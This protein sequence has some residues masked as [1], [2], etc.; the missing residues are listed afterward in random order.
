LICANVREQRLAEMPG[1][2]HPRRTERKFSRI[3]A[4]GA[5][6]VSQ[7][8]HIDL[9]MHHHEHRH[10][11]DERDRREGLVRFERHR[12][13]EELVDALNSRRGHQQR[14]A[15]RFRL[16]DDVGSDIAASTRLVFDDDR[17]AKRLREFFADRARQHVDRAAGRKRRDHAD[18]SVRIALRLGRRCHAGDGHDRQGDHSESAKQ[19]HGVSSLR[20][21]WTG[22]HSGLECNG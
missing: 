22:N 12:L 19:V 7:G 3:G 17:L 1:R 13:V 11:G 20:P 18:G 10:V 9:R 6:Q 8:L 4:R 14:V 21:C 5:D 15:V 2:A 16:G